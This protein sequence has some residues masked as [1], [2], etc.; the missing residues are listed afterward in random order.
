MGAT[1]SSRQ[2]YARLIFDHWQ[3]GSVVSFTECHSQPRNH[4]GSQSLA[5]W[6]SVTRTENLPILHWCSILLAILPESSKIMCWRFLQ[7]FFKVFVLSFKQTLIAFKTFRSPFKS[8]KKRANRIWMLYT[9]WVSEH[10]TTY[11]VFYWFPLQ[12]NTFISSTRIYLK[13][14]SLA[15]L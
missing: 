9:Q 12:I 15:N 4:T 7:V 1:F 10:H 8:S 5:E 2:L 13:N 6:I 14:I 11:T 3:G